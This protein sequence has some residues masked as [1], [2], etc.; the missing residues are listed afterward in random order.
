MNDL[1][2]K[3][4]CVCSAV[5]NKN[6]NNKKPEM[7]HNIPLLFKK[8]GTFRDRTAQ[9]Q[10]HFAAES[11]SFSFRLMRGNTTPLLKLKFLL[12]GYILFV[13]CSFSQGTM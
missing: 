5:K 11:I 4:H 1:L 12:P 6:K 13:A 3:M 10:R 2:Y 9:C 8:E 7:T